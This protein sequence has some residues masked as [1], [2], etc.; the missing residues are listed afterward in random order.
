MNQRNQRTR[1]THKK[2]S[3]CGRKIYVI[4][5]QISPWRIRCGSRSSVERKPGFRRTSKKTRALK[6][7]TIRMN[8]GIPR[9]PRR[10][11]SLSSTGIA[12]HGKG[13]QFA[14]KVDQ[15]VLYAMKANVALFDFSAF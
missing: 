14:R 10:R 7:T 12:R 15:V 5:R 9:K 1:K 13:T 6:A 8:P 4:S 2:L 11:S 3:V